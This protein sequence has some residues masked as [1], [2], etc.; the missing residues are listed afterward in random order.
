MEST[1]PRIRRAFV[2][3]GWTSTVG[4]LAAFLAIL[5]VP[6]DGYAQQQGA[7]Q[8]I[9]ADQVVASVSPNSEAAAEPLAVSVLS[10][11]G[12]YQ[13]VS[14]RRTESG[15]AESHDIWSDVTVIREGSGALILGGY[16]YGGREEEPGEW[17]GGTI[18]SG[19]RKSLSPGDVVVVPAGT[20]HQILL[21]EG[22]SIVYTVVKVRSS[23]GGSG[24]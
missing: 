4:W 11:Q 15:V 18:Q 17:R 8:Y 9:P 10:D 21:D 22:E 12:H 2:K 24:N 5:I 19:Q 16:I 23:E 20:P 6:H 1:K 13:Y 14:V 3:E 7:P